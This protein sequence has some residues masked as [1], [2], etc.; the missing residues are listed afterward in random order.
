MS[1]AKAKRYAK[2]IVAFLGALATL[3][4]E[5]LPQLPSPW[6]ERLAVAIPFATFVTVYLVPN[7]TK[8]LDEG[9]DPTA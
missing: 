9:G 5:V 4:V 1:I 8:V 2:A 7:A 3:L 6:Q